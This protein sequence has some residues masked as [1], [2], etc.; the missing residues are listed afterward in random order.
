MRSVRPP[1]EENDNITIA[2]FKIV[3][4]DLREFCEA[5]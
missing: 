3:E 2:L 1:M 5:L 4:L